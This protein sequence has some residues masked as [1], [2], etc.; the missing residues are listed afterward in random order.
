MAIYIDVNECKVN[1][2]ECEDIC[3]NERGTYHCECKKG[4]ELTADKKTCVDS[5]E[6][7]KDNGGCNQICVNTVGSFE[8]QCRKYYKLEADKKT[9]VG[10]NSFFFFYGY[11]KN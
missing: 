8:C 11:V 9:C 1:N 4:F 6:C 2:G 5:D 10:E 3:V 7:K